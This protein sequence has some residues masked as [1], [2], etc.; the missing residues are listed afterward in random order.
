M[1]LGHL[2]RPPIPELLK[3]FLAIYGTQRFIAVFKR[4]LHLAL[5]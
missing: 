2:G 3:N 4:A 1:E 5:S